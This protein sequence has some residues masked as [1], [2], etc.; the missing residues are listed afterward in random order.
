MYKT[1]YLKELKYFLSTSLLLSLTERLFPSKKYIDTSHTHLMHVCQSIHWSFKSLLSLNVQ[2]FIFGSNRSMVTFDQTTWNT[3]NTLVH[4]SKNISTFLG[5]F[6]I[7]FTWR[8]YKINKKITILF[9]SIQIS[10]QRSCHTCMAWF[11]IHVYNCIL[12][13]LVSN[14]PRQHSPSSWCIQI[15]DAQLVE[16][17]VELFA[18]YHLCEYVC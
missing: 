3:V 18:W 11:Y 10:R 12:P 8:E 7:L 13:K 17:V 1:T 6:S 5:F 14:S 15:S 2:G 4:T 9:L 16:W